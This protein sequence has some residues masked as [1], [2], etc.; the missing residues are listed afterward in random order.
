MKLPDTERAWPQWPSID[1]RPARGAGL[2]GEVPIYYPA[3]P[4]QFDSESPEEKRA[5]TG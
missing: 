4:R 3:E 1:K 2:Y 5:P